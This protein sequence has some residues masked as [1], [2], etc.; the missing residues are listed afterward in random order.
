[1]RELLVNSL[2][3]PAQEK[4]WLAERPTMTIAVDLG[5]KARKQNQ[6]LLRASLLTLCILMDYSFWIDTIY[7]QSSIVCI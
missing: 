5:R 1:M 6:E 2:F 7:L 3:K 4:V